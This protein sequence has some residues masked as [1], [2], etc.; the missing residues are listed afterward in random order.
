M[1]QQLLTQLPDMQRR[2]SISAN[3][4]EN[5]NKQESIQARN[6]S[7]FTSCCSGS[8]K[9]VKST[10]LRKLNE[11]KHSLCHNL[12]FLKCLKE[13]SDFIYLLH[14]L[15]RKYLR[16]YIWFQGGLKRKQNTTGVECNG[17]LKF[18]ET[19]LKFWPSTKTAPYLFFELCKGHDCYILVCGCIL[20]TI[21]LQHHSP[22]QFYL[23]MRFSSCFKQWTRTSAS[24]NQHRSFDL[25]PLRTTPLSDATQRM[26]SCPHWGQLQKYI[27][28][29]WDQDF[30]KIFCTESCASSEV[31]WVRRSIGVM[32]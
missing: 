10:H 17:C 28:F 1:E 24:V 18:I 23:G 32:V 19:L 2:R 13:I 31:S 14:S 25:H 26:K 4:W 21:S 9:Q 3:S 27:C 6:Q 20:H 5:E 15:S 30:T 8:R 16:C 11:P 29:Q 12:Y 22:C 7:G